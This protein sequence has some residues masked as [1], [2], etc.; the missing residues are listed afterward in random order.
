MKQ[1]I[2]GL[3]TGAFSC[4][5]HPDLLN[6]TGNPKI[7]RK[8]YEKLCN[9][10]KELHIPLEMNMLGYATGR[11]YPHPAFFK[12]A[13]EVGN[14][15]ILGCDAHQPGRVADPAEIERSTAFL[16]QC[17]VTNILEEMPLIPPT[18]QEIR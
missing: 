16:R 3:E 9:R 15:V 17:G 7:Y 18:A 6:Y 13:G 14:E 5:A 8:W 11:H 4:F 1:T 12:I 10:A 2:E